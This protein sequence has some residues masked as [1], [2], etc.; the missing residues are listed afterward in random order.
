MEMVINLK[1]FAQPFISHVLCS[2]LAHMALSR[3]DMASNCR[4]SS[5]N[6]FAIIMEE[7]SP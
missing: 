5:T 1:I 3:I 7:R 4:G 2:I 6:S